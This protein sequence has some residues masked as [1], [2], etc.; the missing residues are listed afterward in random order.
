MTYKGYQGKVN[1]DE[2]AGVLHGE[3]IDTRDV[4][5]FQGAS[6]EELKRAFEAS[7]DDYLDFCAS[8]GQGPEKPGRCA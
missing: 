3:V 1:L 4:I 6:P 7:V 5:T 8:R 2:E